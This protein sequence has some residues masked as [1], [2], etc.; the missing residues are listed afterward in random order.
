MPRLKHTQCEPLE[1]KPLEL[2]RVD[3]MWSMICDNPLAFDDFTPLQPEQFYMMVAAENVKAFEIGDGV[4]LALI[5][6]DRG[7]SYGQMV[8]FDYVYRDYICDQL[9]QESWKAGAI[10]FTM[11]VTDDRESAKSLA[12]KHR[13]RHEGTIRKAFWRQGQYHDVNMY[14]MNREE[15]KW[16]Q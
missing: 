10:H 4:G 12:I 14:G 9:L 11:T 13:L 1:L 8:I 2:E 15:Y 5:V 6:L 7:N 3:Y 16:Q